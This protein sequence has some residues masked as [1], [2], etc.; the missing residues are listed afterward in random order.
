MRSLQVP[1]NEASRRK[2]ERAVPAGYM[3][4]IPAALGFFPIASFINIDL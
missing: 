4:T 1:E 3:A 2:N